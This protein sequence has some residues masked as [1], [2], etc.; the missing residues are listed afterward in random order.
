MSKSGMEREA[1]FKAAWGGYAALLRQ[2]KF[3]DGLRRREEEIRRARHT[4]EKETLKAERDSFVK[5]AKSD[6][7]LHIGFC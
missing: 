4:D 6:N 5:K 3:D 1:R 2:E 7:T